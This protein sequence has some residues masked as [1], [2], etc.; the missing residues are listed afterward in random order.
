MAAHLHVK[1]QKNM[2]TTSEIVATLVI[3]AL[4]AAGIFFGGRAAW[5]KRRKR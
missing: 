5:R 2:Q 3:W 4:T 1:E